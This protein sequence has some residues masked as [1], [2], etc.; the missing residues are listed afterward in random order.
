M[1]ASPLAHDT[2]A[3]FKRSK[4]SLRTEMND[5]TAVWTSIRTGTHLL[6]DSRHD[7]MIPRDGS[8][9]GDDMPDDLA[10]AL[11]WSG[12]MVDEDVDEDAG[13]RQ[14]YATARA[15]SDTLL[16][17]LSPTV[18]CNLACGYCF[19]AE[20]PVRYFDEDDERNLLRFVRQRLRDG[21]RHVDVTWFG[22][23]PLLARRT[24]D[25]LS[26]RLIQS[27]SFAGATYA[28]NVITNGTL[29]DD[30]VAEMLARSRVQSVQITVDG[31]PDIH[32]QLR[33][34]AS[35][36]G[37]FERTLAGVEAAARHLQVDLRVNVDRRNARL[38]PR[39]L[40]ELVSRGLTSVNLGFVRTEPPAVY[41]ASDAQAVDR[42]FLTVPDFA[43]R[44]VEWLT[45]AAERGFAVG[46]VVDPSDPT[47][48][49]AV[50]ENHYAFEP[51][52]RVARCWADVT[53]EAG[54][55][56]QLG[57]LGV[58]TTSVDD[59]W[60]EYE[61]FDS[62]CETCPFLPI[63]WGGCPK[64]RLDGAMAGAPPDERR[65]FKEKYVCSP[66]KFNLSELLRRGLVVG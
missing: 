15:Q 64:A 3:R 28:A 55:V 11:V 36:G 53:D 12:I 41:G 31:P 6:L 22:G 58:T 23:E 4:F 44:E 19:E 52:G 42:I 66:R 26:R 17:T 18:A 8:V 16:L 29:I 57:P 59:R 49:G 24:I 14:D 13:A 37:S 34:S 50:K 48:C 21:V 43:A 56:G 32:D 2:N 25:R 35:G 10:D 46:A 51:G 63:C 33:P 7:S 45:E 40:D 39:L 54:V 47:P 61:P 1:N 5:E 65:S 60:R 20:H 30:A 38:V 62:G 27:C 9:A